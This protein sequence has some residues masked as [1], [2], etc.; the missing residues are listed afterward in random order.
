MK[1]TGFFL[2]APSTVQVDESFRV[3]VKVLGEPYVVDT[4]CSRHIPQVVGRY[5]RSPRGI[6]Y[7]D[8]VLPEWKG[9]IEIKGSSGYEGPCSLS[10]E[11]ITGPYE[12]DHRPITRIEDVRFRE[13]GIKFITVSDPETGKTATTNPI[14]VSDEP[15]HERLFWGDLHSHT[16]FS[17]GLRCPEELY[18][19]ARE[20]AFLDIFA[21][22]DHAERLTDRQWEYFTAVTNDF[23]VPGSFVTLVGLEWTSSRFGHRNVYYPEAQGPILRSDDPVYG[24]LEKVY[25]VAL[26]RG[27]L[28][29]PHHSANAVMGVD[30]S[31]GHK[32][33]VERLVE[34]HSIWGNSERP[35]SDGNPL[36][37]LFAGGEKD[38]QHVVDAL[39]RGY[40]FGFIGG[41][42]IHDGRPGDELHALQKQPADYCHLRRQGIMGVWAKALTR[43]AIFEAL[44]SRR[45]FATTNVRI[46]LRFSVCDAPMGS[47]IHHR[48]PRFIKV[49]AASEVPFTS[50]ELVRNGADVVRIQPHQREVSWE[51]EDAGTEGADWYYVRLVRED[52]QLAWSSPVWVDTL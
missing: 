9:R 29:I 10:F 2:A 15:P 48:G 36:P 16:F 4:A 49:F 12:D 1:P 34:I 17:D 22:S 7:M 23:N 46:I 5:N 35:A 31:L 52:G 8:N 45:V 38:G 39:R 42:D 33:E 40:R 26:E 50:V 25:E 37:I 13:P 41:G 51:I 14:V 27:A 28:V 3:G 20:E 44:W 6:A 43:E 19:F 24:E 32:P 30:W 11:G 47:E 18:A 21:L